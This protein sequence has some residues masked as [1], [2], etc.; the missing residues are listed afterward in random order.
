MA[1][2]EAWNKPDN[3]QDVTMNERETVES[4]RRD[5]QQKDD[6]KME[7]AYHD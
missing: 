3:K 4:H 1:S 5:G 7:M 2:R 6:N